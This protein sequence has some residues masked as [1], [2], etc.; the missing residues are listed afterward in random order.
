MTVCA[1]SPAT[2]TVAAT[3]KT[4]SYQWQVSTNG[5][6]TFSNITDNATNATYTNAATT[7]A[8]N[9]N[10]Y[11]A[12]VSDQCTASQTSTQ[13]VLTVN[14]PATASTGGNQTIC[15]GNDTPALGGTAGGGAT[16]GA[17]TTSGDG[18]FNPNATTL[19]ATYSPGFAD[20]TAGTATLTLTTTGQL[21]PCPAATAQLVV[22]I[23][24]GATVNAG[25][26]QT[27][28]AGQST[29]GLG[30]TIDGSATNGL[31]TSSGTGTFTP[32]ATTPN[33]T[34][35]P[36]PADITAGTVTLT[37][38]T[39]DQPAPCPAVAVNV[40]VT[41]NT[42]AQVNAGPN[43]T[44]CASSPTVTLAGSFGGG[45]SSAT[46][47]GAGTFTPNNTTLNATYTPTGAEVAAGSATVTLTTDDPAGP[48]GLANATM[49]VTINPAATVA[50]G[51]NQTVC[52][53]SPAATLAGSFGG[54]ASSAT[55]SGGG[56][57]FIPNS[58]TLNA[59]YTPSASEITAGS[60]TVT[61]TTDDPA[62][63]CGAVSASM[64][65]TINPA[66]V[67]GAG[68]NQTI[69]ASSDTAP[70]GG[71]ASGG[72]TGGLWS[73]GSG[74]FSP[75]ATALNAIYHP[76]Q[77]DISVGSV[78]LTLTTTGQLSPC[79]AATA[80]VLV[81]INAAPAIAG[82][83]ANQTVAA[84]VPATFCVDATGAG[85]TYQ[86]Q[87]SMN[88]GV[89]YTNISDSATNACYTNMAPTLLQDGTR[90]QVVVNGTCSPGTTST[91]PAVLTVGTPPTVYAGA[92][93][94]VCALS[95]TTQLA[96]QI[97]NGATGATWTGAGNFAPNSTTLNATYTPT[98]GE[99][100]AGTA[101]VTLTTTP[102]GSVSSSMTIT[103]NA[104]PP[105][106]AGPNQTVCG[107]PATIQLAGSFGAPSTFAYWSGA[108]TFSPN[109]YALN[110]VYTP[111]A[112]ELAA[113]S[114]TV[115]LTTDDPPGPCG[116]VSSTVTIS[117]VAPATVSAGSNQ[118]ILAGQD[119][120]GLGGT[121]GGA[122]TGAIW[123]SP[124]S[125]TFL[126]NAT[127]LN[128]T[129]H[130]SAAD[131]TAGLGHADADGHG[132]GCPL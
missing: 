125:G 108:G 86:W 115:T 119:T 59:T 13:A 45:A 43:Q 3:G 121:I 4:L 100:A 75:D 97:G 23:H 82:Q 80:H 56:G 1:G 42:P 52:A 105:V 51:P 130:P 10:Q 44:V 98:A 113:N 47:S 67:A 8:D 79:G 49:T 25:P 58:T 39:T 126:P 66:A 123:S 26:N 6:V 111:T 109:I 99:I 84:G 76:S 12:I 31:W 53:S 112:G 127:T 89:S 50:A 24:P 124:T 68:G 128:A 60:A 32:N 91:P 72:A 27:L 55:W 57:N 106:S 74:T 37:L 5:G 110:A 18:S 16:G 78:M 7:L 61:L 63:A 83:P 73:G 102:P 96:G 81:T 40:T 17:W 28:C 15:A 9:A 87:V 103:I 120:A 95:A 2:F 94:T 46:W 93:Q 22:T 34:Y 41:I 129:Y 131:I 117:M 11:Q 30:G 36:S 71:T 38:T 70:L 64:T 101:T 118:T 69:C 77:N 132:P 85:L 29:A 14:A 19:N 92:N 35:A 114:V 62:G 65:I 20:M 54:A 104:A 90:Y 107:T 48:C 116:P 33:A 21:A 88:G 122:A